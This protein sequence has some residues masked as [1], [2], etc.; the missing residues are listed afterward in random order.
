[1]NLGDLFAQWEAAGIF[2]YALPFLLIFALIF[3]ILTKINIFG[4]KDNP[5]KG[6]NAIISLAIAFMALQFNMV[7]SFFADLFPRFGIALA[8]ILV[9]L[10]AIGLFTD[11][12]DKYMKWILYAV[13]LIALIV[14]LWVPLSGLGFTIN[15]DGFFRENLALIFFAV[16]MIGLIIWAIAGGKGKSSGGGKPL[17]NQSP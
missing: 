9:I 12:G 15:L 6:V 1:M 11:L 16:I 2:A 5:N 14:V 17:D 3:G 13:V 10:I 7:S 8:V 4:S